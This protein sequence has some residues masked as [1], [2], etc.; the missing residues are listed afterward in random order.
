[1][2]SDWKTLHS[3]YQDEERRHDIPC[4]VCGEINF[5][6]LR[7]HMSKKHKELDG[8]ERR[9]LMKE[10]RRLDAMK[11]NTA[12]F[13]EKV[14]GANGFTKE[15]IMIEAMKQAFLTIINDEKH[16]NPFLLEG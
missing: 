16:L 9:R 5:T 1:M 3:P 14:D 8:T 12:C 6:R 4:P 10:G 7:N 2:N 15:G 11:L 13:S